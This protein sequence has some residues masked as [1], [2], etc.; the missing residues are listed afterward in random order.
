MIRYV[1]LKKAKSKSRSSP[2]FV[3]RPDRLEAQS[4]IRAMH[5]KGSVDGAR[6]A[7]ISRRDGRPES[8]TLDCRRPGLERH[9]VEESSTADD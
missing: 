2:P 1:C 3:R 7:E 5:E 6:E 8:N 4:A 9:D